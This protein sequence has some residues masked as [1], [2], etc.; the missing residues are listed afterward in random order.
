M[1]GGGEVCHKNPY[2]EVGHPRLQILFLNYGLEASHRDCE[3][4]TSK[5]IEAAQTS[6]EEGTL[7]VGGK[8]LQIC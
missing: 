1:S 7:H 6:L 8:I 4:P 3:K 5:P 2:I